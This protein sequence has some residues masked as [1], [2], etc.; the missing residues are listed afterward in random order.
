MII[1]HDHI[2]MDPVK[3]A[4]VANWPTPAN[5]KDVQQFLGFTNF[6]RR[7]IWDFSDDARPLFNLTKK[8][9]RGPGPKR[10]RPRSKR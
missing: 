7:F 10:R 5:R 8:D 9:T 4:G 3:V 1:S 6:Y 2:E